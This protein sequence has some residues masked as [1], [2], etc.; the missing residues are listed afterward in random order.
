MLHSKIILSD[1]NRRVKVVLHRLF[2]I[3]KPMQNLGYMTIYF[4]SK[5]N[6]QYSITKIMKNSLTA[7]LGVISHLAKK[8]PFF[9]NLGDDIY[10]HNQHP[11]FDDNNVSLHPQHEAFDTDGWRG[12]HL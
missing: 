8:S 2:L 10:L 4:F 3:L 6:V 7:S 5:L 9:C 1:P 11:A 12:D